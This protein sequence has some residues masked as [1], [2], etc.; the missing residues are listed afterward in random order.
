MLPA[1]SPTRVRFERLT[2]H[3]MTPL[4]RL[5]EINCRNLEAVSIPF[6][7]MKNPPADADGLGWSWLVPLLGELLKPSHEQ[8]GFEAIPIL[9]R[10][11]IIKKNFPPDSLVRRSFERCLY[12][13][14][15]DGVDLFKFGQVNRFVINFSAVEIITQ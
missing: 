10:F 6:S 1:I 4:A 11:V 8:I 2:R 14:R 13:L 3:R 12:D 15:F 9:R 7:S 5:Y